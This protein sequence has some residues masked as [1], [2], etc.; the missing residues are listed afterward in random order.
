[1]NLEMSDWYVEDGS[2]VRVK[3]IQLGYTLPQSLTKQ[4]TISNLR[5]FLAVQNLF[6][7][8]GYSGLDPEIGSD[9][10]QYMGIDMG[11]YPQARTCMF[12]ISMNL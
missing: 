1:M 7:L 6:T 12:G 3:N 11:F 4:V 8:T 10:P 2:Y 9:N 5:F